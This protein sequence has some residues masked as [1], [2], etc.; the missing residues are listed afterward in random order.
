MTENKQKCKRG[1]CPRQAPA[2]YG[3]YCA[4]HAYALG[5][6]RPLVSA[7][8]LRVQV[9]RELSRGVTRYALAK[10]AGLNPMT[11]RDIASGKSRRVRQST[12]ERLQGALGDTNSRPAWPIQRRLCALRRL[13]WSAAALAQE[14]GVQESTVIDICLGNT[15]M[16]YASTYEAAVALYDV[17]QHTMVGDLDRRILRKRWPRPMD[18]DD[19]DDPEECPRLQIRYPNSPGTRIVSSV[20]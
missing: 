17:L 4:V 11:V 14:L 16:V 7:S 3:G 18:W 20:I 12:A 10:R 8:A 2:G 1:S 5:V 15:T 9:N 6:V 19:I 13:G